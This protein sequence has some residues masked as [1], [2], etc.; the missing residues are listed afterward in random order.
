M[1]DTLNN[2]TK[3][4]LSSHPPTP[5][6]LLL[7][8]SLMLFPPP[9]TPTPV[10]S[11]SIYRVLRNSDWWL[12]LLLKESEHKVLW[13]IITQPEAQYCEQGSLSLLP[14]W[15][16]EASCLAATAAVPFQCKNSTNLTPQWPQASP[17]MEECSEDPWCEIHPWDGPDQTEEFRNL[18]RQYLHWWLSA[19]CLW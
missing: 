9:P 17:E 15:Y 10:L 2:N 5:R 7:S 19:W 4:S 11:P 12:W 16:T 18:A 8:G 6:P 3:L 13:V 1:I 14:S